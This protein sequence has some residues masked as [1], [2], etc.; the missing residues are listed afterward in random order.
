MWESEYAQGF[1][2]KEDLGIIHNWI[3]SHYNH[4]LLIPSSLL[5]SSCHFPWKIS[6]QEIS[7][8]KA[9]DSGG[10]GS[11]LQ[12]HLWGRKRKVF[13][14]GKAFFPTLEIASATQPDGVSKSKQAKRSGDAHRVWSPS[15]YI[16]KPR[17]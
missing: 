5:F 9:Q 12:S 13:L 6:N 7:G 17:K 4:N 14:L 8:K 16:C 15:T 2:R 10:D 3:P 11:C 1:S